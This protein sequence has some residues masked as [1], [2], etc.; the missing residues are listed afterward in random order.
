MEEFE[1]WYARFVHVCCTG[2]T[3]VKSRRSFSS[4]TWARHSVQ[5]PIMSTLLLFKRLIDRSVLHIVTYLWQLQFWRKSF[6]F[7]LAAPI[8]DCTCARFLQRLIQTRKVFTALLKNDFHK[9]LFNSCFFRFT[10]VFKTLL[11]AYSGLGYIVG[12][13]AAK[14]AGTWQWALRV[15]VNI[16]F[17][18]APIPA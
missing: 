13:A 1:V 3:V 5:S 12:A 4:S 14:A 11:F 8:C 6:A 17:L 10:C 7:L 15:S 18:V 9:D 16:M 2:C